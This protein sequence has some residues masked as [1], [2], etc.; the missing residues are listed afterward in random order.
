MEVDKELP[1]SSGLAG[2][3]LECRCL[4]K[5][6]GKMPDMEAKSAM[7]PWEDLTVCDVKGKSMDCFGSALFPPWV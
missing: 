1:L 2:P 4:P 6:T 7:G 5:C 3:C